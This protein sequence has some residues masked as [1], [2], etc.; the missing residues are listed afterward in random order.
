[1]LPQVGQVLTHR[2]E[3][4]RVLLT[5]L[6]DF[7]A[8]LGHITVGATSQ[9]TGC[10]RV[11]L[12]P[13]HPVG[14][15]TD[16]GFQRGHALGEIVRLSHDRQRTGAAAQALNIRAAHCTAW[17]WARML[18]LCA[19]E[20]LRARFAAPSAAAGSHPSKRAVSGRITATIPACGA[21]VTSAG[22]TNTT[23]PCTSL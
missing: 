5:K 1:S 9:H 11:V 15:L 6:P 10:R 18:A 3:H 8:D 14:Q 19:K 4:P 13:A 20:A 23:S 17:R 21:R 7:P 2:V 16:P 12:T 22:W